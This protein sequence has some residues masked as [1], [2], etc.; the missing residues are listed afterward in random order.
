MRLEDLATFVEAAEA[1]SLVGAARVLGVPK[2]T[3]SRR[4]ARLES[5][6]GEELLQRHARLFRLTDIGQGLYER[7]AGSVRDLQRAT[8]EVHDAHKD[9]AGELRITMPQDLGASDAM[10]GLFTSFRAAYPSIALYL[11]FSDRRVDLVAERF[12]FAIRAHIG[13]LDSTDALKVRRLGRMSV[14]LYASP[15]YLEHA[16]HPEHPSDLTAHAMLAPHFQRGAFDWNLVHR[17]TGDTVQIKVTS[18]FRASGI[19]F[20]PFVAAQG[21]GIAPVPQF[22]AVSSQFG[23]SLV[24]VLP[25]W[26]LPSATLSLLWPASRLPHPRRRAFLDYCAKHLTWLS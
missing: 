14:R 3:V 15:A 25:D 12:D 1:G 26:E 8:R 23:R 7:S 10:V 19:T 2:S 20:L 9:V 18:D 21:A 11:E 4:V 5:D 16:G 6:L 17:T 22:T 13:P 24:P